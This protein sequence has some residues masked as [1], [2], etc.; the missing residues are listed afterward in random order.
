MKL[1]SLVALSTQLIK[2]CV[3]GDALDLLN[4]TSQHLINGSYLE[5][6]FLVNGVDIGHY[7]ADSIGAFDEKDFHRFG[8]D[9]GT[10]LRK[11]LL[12]KNTNATRL[13]EGIPDKIIIQKATDGLMR[14]F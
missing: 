6:Q 8:S 1:S 11:I 5:H 12:S 4:K 2:N 7:L 9:I 3:H 14:G 10:S 13:P